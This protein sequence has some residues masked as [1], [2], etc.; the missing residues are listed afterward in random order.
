MRD[1]LESF[2]ISE[3][4]EKKSYNYGFNMNLFDMSSDQTS[5]LPKRIEGSYEGEYIVDVHLQLNQWNPR[6][7]G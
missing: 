3:Y 1:K 2:Q 5:D 4:F 6:G 7:F